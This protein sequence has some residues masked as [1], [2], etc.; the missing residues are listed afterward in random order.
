MK[1]VLACNSLLCVI[2]FI[3]LAGLK[4][5]LKSIERQLIRRRQ[6]QASNPVILEMK[7]K[8]LSGMAMALNDTLRQ[9]NKLRVSQEIKEQEFKRLVT[10]IS[11]DLRTP[12]TVLKGYLQMMGR[13]GL[14]KTSMEYLKICFRHSN[15]MEKRI[16]Q[17]FEYSYWVSQEEEITLE[18]T[19]I[20]NIITDVMTDFIPVFEEN[21]IKMSLSCTGVY[22]GMAD[23]ELLRRI[24]QNL[25]KNAL[26]YSEGDVKVSIERPEDTSYIKILVEN[27]VAG[28]CNLDVKQVFNRFYVGNEERNHSTGLGLAIVKM[29][30]ERMGGK[31]FVNMEEGI[32]SAGFYLKE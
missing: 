23:K 15:E 14:D 21:N 6:E 8:S 17:F 28:N 11:H 5:Q 32:F 12:L 16:Q 18:K 29:L 3:Y 26:Q 9:E 13:R 25:L 19:N 22:Y 24:I 20:T 10:N 2:L 27:P 31:V 7:D 4:K 30:A 1:F